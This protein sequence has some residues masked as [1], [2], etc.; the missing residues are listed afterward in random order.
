MLKN[1]TNKKQRSFT[2][3]TLNNRFV[4][5]EKLPDLTISQ[6][7]EYWKHVFSYCDKD[8][9]EKELYLEYIQ[10]SD[11]VSEERRCLIEKHIGS[12]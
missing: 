1:K 5:I 9:E 7:K 10:L 11:Y 8:L 6:L 2:Y 3:E 4:F 12:C